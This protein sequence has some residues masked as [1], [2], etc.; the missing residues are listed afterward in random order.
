MPEEKDKDKKKDD[1]PKKQET[2]AEA[3]LRIVKDP[4]FDQ[5]EFVPKTPFRKEST[6]D[7][8]TD[9]HPTPPKK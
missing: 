5:S 9:K 4:F 8:D 2:E 1:E 7:P 3:I 6:D